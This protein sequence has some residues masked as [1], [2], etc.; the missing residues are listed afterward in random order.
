MTEPSE[1]TR[2]KFKNPPITELAIALFYPP[3][4]ELKSQHIGLYWQQ[5][6]EKYPICEQQNPIIDQTRPEASATLQTAPGEIFPLPRFWFQSGEH[7]MLLQ[8]Q[9]NGF[10][11]NWRRGEKTAEK[12]D[13]P[14]YEHVEKQF[15]EEF[16]KYTVFIREVVGGQ[17]QA[18]DRCELTYVNLI[19]RDPEYFS[20][21]SDLKN[22][23]PL[24]NGLCEIYQG[25]HELLNASIVYKFSDNLL[26]EI[27]TKL[28]RRID[29][30]D[31]IALMQLRAHGNPAETSFD[32]AR[33]WYR[34]AHDA[35]Y[36]TFRS[37]TNERVQTD[38]WKPL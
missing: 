12:A 18:V 2:V 24:L 38:L 17:L 28:G 27:V 13:Y 16:E 32:G 1:K 23:L 20:R 15:W 14:Q 8:L 37:I 35:I 29:T 21:P 10:M 7:P 4:T 11:L 3:I 36:E 33:D 5:V 22:V 31:Q 6:F 34:S 9:R 19:D 25:A 26:L 30:Q